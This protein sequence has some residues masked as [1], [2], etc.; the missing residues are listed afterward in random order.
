MD[1][2][3]STVTV[4]VV[5]TNDI[6]VIDTGAGAVKEDT[7]LTAQGTLHI[8]DPDAGQAFFQTQTNTAGTYGT[9]SI[10]ANGNWHYNLNNNDLIVQALNKGESHIETFVVKSIDGTTST[11]SVT[12]VGTN[13]PAKLT[14]NFDGDIEG[15]A[16]T[17]HRLIQGTC[18]VSDVDAGQAAF[19]SDITANETYGTFQFTAATGKWVFTLNDSAYNLTE[20]MT[21]QYNITSIEGTSRLLTII[22]FGTTPLAPVPNDHAGIM[23]EI[24]P[25]GTELLNGKLNA[26][27]PDKAAATHHTDAVSRET[28]TVVAA[29]GHAKAGAGEIAAAE[30]HPHGVA[31]HEPNIVYG[32]QK[33]AAEPA[34]DKPS[35]SIAHDAPQS[36]DGRASHAAPDSHHPATAD[37]GA[38]GGA[39]IDT[40]KW[41]LGEPSAAAK[42][43]PARNGVADHSPRGEKDALDL[44]DL[45]PEGGHRAASLDSYLNGHKEGADAAADARHQSP[46]AAAA[47]GPENVEL[48]HAAALSD[49]QLLKNLLNHG[50][51]HTE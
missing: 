39:G 24:Q 35:P 9:F 22:V 33:A 30:S 42:P 29:A 36:T 17:G 1:G 50:Q 37:A 21:Y 34:G 45:L 13:D 27:T 28:S 44:K 16:A 18:T 32:A 4:T 2:T 19:R 47:P 12:V 6:P 3:T 25:T 5:G 14:G 7:T 40:F 31:S 41:T 23:A 8:T 46:G 49:A 26:A 11:V 43:E 38:P 20:N 51:Q 10:D 48:A 15:N